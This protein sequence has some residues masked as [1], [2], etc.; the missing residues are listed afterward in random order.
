VRIRAHV[1][2]RAV[3]SVEV[4]LWIA[5]RGWALRCCGEKRAVGDFSPRYGSTS[6]S[7]TPGGGGVRRAGCGIAPADV[8]R[9]FER[10]AR[11]PYAADRPGTDLGLPIVKAITEAHGGTVTV[12]SRPTHGSTFRLRLGPARTPGPT[13]R[14]ELPLSPGRR[15]P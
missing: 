11:G 14:S 6:W 8:D 10:F 15:G 1:V 4:W 2:V 3:P 12:T 7:T 13:G 5:R 9:V